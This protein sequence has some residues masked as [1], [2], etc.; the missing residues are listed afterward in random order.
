MVTSL[1]ILLAASMFTGTLAFGQ[2]SGELLLRSDDIA[3]ASSDVFEDCNI[4]SYEADGVFTISAKINHPT[5]MTLQVMS[6]DGKL[7]Y[8]DHIGFTLGTIQRNIDISSLFPGF[9]IVKLVGDA[10]SRSFRIPVHG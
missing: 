6:E 2:S 7:I 1:R 8:T 9:Y 4:K 5:N 10:E 3:Y